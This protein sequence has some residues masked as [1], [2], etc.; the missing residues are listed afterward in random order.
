MEKNQLS[1]TVRMGD[2]STIKLRLGDILVT[3]SNT[4]YAVNRSDVAEFIPLA[5]LLVAIDRYIHFYMLS[6]YKFE[7][8]ISKMED[9]GITILRKGKEI[10]FTKRKILDA[11]SAFTSNMRSTRISVKGVDIYSRLLTLTPDRIAK[12]ECKPLN[13]RV[14]DLSKW[15]LEAIYRWARNHLRLSG[16]RLDIIWGSDMNARERVEYAFKS[17]ISDKLVKERRAATQPEASAYSGLRGPRSGQIQDMSFVNLEIDELSPANH[18][19]PRP[20]LTPESFQEYTI[21]CVEDKEKFIITSHPLDPSHQIKVIFSHEDY[22]GAI[23]VF[24]VVTYSQRRFEK[25]RA[26]KMES[27]TVTLQSNLTFTINSSPHQVYTIAPPLPS[28]TSAAAAE[29]VR[30]EEDE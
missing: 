20:D 2:G 13:V 22:Y 17:F 1:K 30:E 19:R 9:D 29:E 11:I 15:P 25:Y 21:I 23:Y 14:P 16:S 26:R 3:N 28:A 8:T 10:K 18:I 27:P 12:M 7:V 6:L 24:S 5:M 4:L